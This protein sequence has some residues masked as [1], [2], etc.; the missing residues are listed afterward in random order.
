M[1]AC[2]LI[3]DFYSGERHLRRWNIFHR[4][5]ALQVS[6]VES[7]PRAL[8]RKQHHGC[9]NG[10]QCTQWRFVHAIL[11][12]LHS[13]AASGAEGVGSTPEVVTIEA[14]CFGGCIA[15]A[16]TLLLCRY[17]PEASGSFQSTFRVVRFQDR[18][19][20]EKTIDRDVSLSKT[21]FAS[22][23]SRQS[24]LSCVKDLDWAI[25]PADEDQSYFEKGAQGVLF[26]P[27]PVCCR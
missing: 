5:S 23:V 12:E 25:K 20:S 8:P 17:L 24:L 6:E 19:T 14:L 15:E 11:Q 18:M 22:W 7:R 13:S 21:S 3:W 1:L 4:C 27:S 2:W 9:W 26:S 16:R 10:L